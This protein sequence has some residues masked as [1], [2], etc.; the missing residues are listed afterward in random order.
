MAQETDEG[1]VLREHKIPSSP[2]IHAVIFV[3]SFFDFF[4]IHGPPS[5]APCGTV[6]RNE[7]RGHRN[8]SR[9]FRQGEYD[10]LLEMFV[11]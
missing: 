9:E 2:S 6:T 3:V 7:E 11:K 8:T 5:A 4:H 1:Q 10:V